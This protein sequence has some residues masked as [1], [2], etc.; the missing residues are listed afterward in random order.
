MADTTRGIRLIP[1]AAKGAAI[2][3]ANTVPGVSGGTIAVVTGIY[4]R[5]IE[6]IGDFISPR[7][8]SHLAFLAPVFVGIVAGIAGFAWI[9]ELGLTR[10]PE[11]TFFFFAGLIAGSLPFI[12]RQLHGHKIR[13]HYIPVGVAACALM[14]AQATLGEPAMSEAIT[15]VTSTTILPLLGAGAIA[16]A[17]M[18]IPGVSGSF[19]LLIIGMYA[20]FLQAVRTGNIPVLL[21]L[22]VGAVVGLVAVSK[23]MS[24][25]IKR[26]HATTYWLILGLVAGSVVGIWPGISSIPA[27]LLDAAAAVLGV[28]LAL[29]L[30]K[31]PS[32]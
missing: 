2:G 6:A 11:Q 12:V 3:A 21:V 7:W 8:K 31:R 27:A 18:I 14:I 25:L 24:F 10:A 32:R 20:T 4:D 19:V 26:Y 17:T 13:V 15:R 29:L 9:I 30:G 23:A 28:V 16:T 1:L 22:A 5:L